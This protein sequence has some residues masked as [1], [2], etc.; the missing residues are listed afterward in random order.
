MGLLQ[1]LVGYVCRVCRL[2]KGLCCC[3]LESLSAGVVRLGLQQGLLCVDCLSG[4]L[5]C[6]PGSCCCCR[7]PGLCL[8]N[9][10]YGILVGGCVGL[11]CLPG[12][13]MC[14]CRHLELAQGDVPLILKL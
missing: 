11:L 10:I 4:S 6:V 14:G 7:L 5:V 2:A 8:R 9:S 3:P 12:L 1:G 13:C